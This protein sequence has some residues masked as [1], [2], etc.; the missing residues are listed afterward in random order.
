M[1]ADFLLTSDSL[2]LASGPRWGESLSRSP[3]I[4]RAVPTLNH[5]STAKPA[6]D[7]K[8]IFHGRK[9]R[10]PKPETTRCVETSLSKL[11]RSLLGSVD[12]PF[13]PPDRG[14]SIDF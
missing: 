7:G 1:N 6:E 11:S 12:F 2:L 10:E 13:P 5:G 4:R 8:S 3:V 14:F 9:P